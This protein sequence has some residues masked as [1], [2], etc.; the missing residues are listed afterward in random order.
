MITHKRLQWLLNRLHFKYEEQ[1]ESIFKEFQGYL[2][3]IEA[4]TI[5]MAAINSVIKQRHFDFE[6]EKDDRGMGY[7][8][9]ERSNILEYA[10]NIVRDYI[11]EVTDDR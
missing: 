4:G 10:I 9:D 5:D 2:K 8:D 6:Y 3:E 11:Q 7:T 1:D